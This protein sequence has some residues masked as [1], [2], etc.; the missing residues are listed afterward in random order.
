MD[1]IPV[2]I[3]PNS[4]S[5]RT[6]FLNNRSLARCLS[7]SYALSAVSHTIDFQATSQLTISAR[8]RY[9]MEEAMGKRPTTTESQPSTH[10]IEH[11]N[12]ET[13]A[14]W[15]YKSLK[16]GPISLP[17][18]ASPESQLLMVSFVCFLCPGKAIWHP[19]CGTLLTVNRHVQRSQ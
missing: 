2:R 9:S 4:F 12:L 5:G 18:Y 6:A 7:K 17:W 16:L 3:T 15:R 8:L 14:G 11:G 1:T 19:I 10:S 13:P